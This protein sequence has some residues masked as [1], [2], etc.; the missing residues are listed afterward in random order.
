MFL[1]IPAIGTSSCPWLET[2]T[3]TNKIKK[4]LNSDF[5]GTMFLSP[6]TFALMVLRDLETRFIAKHENRV[7]EVAKQK[8]TGKAGRSQ[9]FSRTPSIETNPK[10][11]ITFHAQ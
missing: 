11:G 6:D 8:Q 9:A 2:R 5:N 7:S 3:C 10:F 4:Q 1:S